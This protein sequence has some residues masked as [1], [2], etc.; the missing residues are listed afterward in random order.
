MVYYAMILTG[1]LLLTSGC[2]HQVLKEARQHPILME[3]IYRQ[4]MGDA[5]EDV[6]KFVAEHLKEQKTFGYVKPYVPVIEP[7]VVK[8]V[9]V[10][11]H[12]SQEDAG[13]LIAGHWVY[14]MI[15]GP[16]WFIDEEVKENA[17]PII[18]P[19]KLEKENN[20]RLK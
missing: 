18:I 19:G 8:K 4:S 16:K 11:D 13:V 6:G 7:P 3:D 1:Y 20:E 2:A 14:L 5:K 17:V 15:Q 10:P 12:K 9:W